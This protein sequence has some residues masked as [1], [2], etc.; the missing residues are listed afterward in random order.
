[1]ALVLVLGALAARVVD[2]QVFQSTH[3]SAQAR[4]ELAVHVSVPAVRAGI[5]DRNG[6]VLALSVPTKTVVADDFQIAHPVKEAAIL[7]A[8]TGVPAATLATELHQHSGYVPL[9]RQVSLSAAAKIA[10]QKLPGITL[11]DSSQRTV[12]NGEL[13]SPVIGAV[14]A[15]GAGSGG[16]EYQYQG[17]LAGRAGTETLLESPLGVALP[18]SSVAVSSPARPGVGIETTIDEPLQFQTEQALAS[19][20]LSTQALSG[21]AVVMDVR[22]GEILS[23]ASLVS[24]NQ[25]TVQAASR[26]TQTPAATPDPLPSGVAEASSNL[27]VT[28][29]FEPGSVF[30][31]VPFSAALQNGIISPN[32]RFSVPDTLSLDQSTFHDAESHPTEELTATDIL[33]QS[34]NIGTAEITEDLGETQL[35]A[36]VRQ[37]GFGVPTGLN[38]PGESNGLLLPTSQWEPTDYV[39]LPIGQVDAVTAQQVL[40]AYN[41]VANGGVLVK[42]RLVRATVGS[43]G[44]AEA[45]KPAPG[46]PVVSPGT[47]AA[48]NAMLKQVVATGTGTAAVVPGYTVAGKTGTAEIPTP[49]QDSYE[50]GAYMSSFVGYAPANKPVLSAIVVLDRPTP[51][52]GGTVAAPVFSQIMSYALHRYGIPTTPGASSQPSSGASGTSQQQDIT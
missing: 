27:A 24:T 41:A 10:A 48:L 2:V 17:M 23:M 20:I 26:S 47:D 15:S 33:S 49:N 35:L 18:Q 50:A 5:Y 1:V 32:T 12:P 39:D 28:Q 46:V 51:I 19:A 6:Q 52:F 3:Y 37:L 29:V 8:L 14:N 44:K 25:G 30:K 40:D 43:D 45:L 34:S 4:Q 9:A 38:F 13:A 31:L 7:S 42:P 16:L 21:T 11:M 36:Q 22:T